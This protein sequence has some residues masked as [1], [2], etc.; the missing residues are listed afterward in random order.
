MHDRKID[1]LNS[2]GVGLLGGQVTVLN[3][4]RRLSAAEAR[5]FAAWLVT[6]ADVADPD[7]VPFEQVLEAV[8]NA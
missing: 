8:Q 1:T 4:A 6:V 7:G 3:P 2:R 5:V